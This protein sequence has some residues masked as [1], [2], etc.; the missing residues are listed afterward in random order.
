MGRRLY[1]P[2][3]DVWGLPPYLRAA[4]LPGQWVTA[5]P[6]GPLGRYMGQTRAE[7]DVVAWQGNA[8]GRG[9]SYG[10]ALRAYAKAGAADLKGGRA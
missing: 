9:R 6:G 4:I 1:V 10:A 3:F 2:A 8:K 5:G 7:S